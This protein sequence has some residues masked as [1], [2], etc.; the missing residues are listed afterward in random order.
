MNAK[1][2]QSNI[3]KFG[4]LCKITNPINLFYSSIIFFTDIKEKD[5]L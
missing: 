1:G 5:I 2:Y 4:V 3:N